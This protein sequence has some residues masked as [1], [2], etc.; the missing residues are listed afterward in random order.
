[1]KRLLDSVY[2]KVY[3]VLLP[4]V[5]G[6]TFYITKKAEL[7]VSQLRYNRM[8]LSEV[9]AENKAWIFTITAF[10]VFTSIYALVIRDVYR[11]HKP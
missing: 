7:R 4:I 10:V 6:I 1:M 8:D 3:L 11:K 9:N 2:F 5:L